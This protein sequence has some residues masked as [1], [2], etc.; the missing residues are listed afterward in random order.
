MLAR[1]MGIWGKYDYM[2][3]FQQSKMTDWTK[4]KRIGENRDS[5]KVIVTKYTVPPDI[6]KE[7]KKA[8][9]VYGS[10]GRALQ[11]ATEVLIRM[12]KPPGVERVS[13]LKAPGFVRI[14][15][16]LHKRTFELIRKMAEL[17]Y[18]D[19]PGQVISA[20]VKVLNWKRL[21]I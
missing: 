14:S 6:A 1:L 18:N 16:R 15:M 20:C 9:P 21:K 4:Q 13:S 3:E 17:E 11:V 10:Q 7:I 2:I 12:D 19:D 5:A 8:G